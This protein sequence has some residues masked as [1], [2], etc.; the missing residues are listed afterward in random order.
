MASSDLPR[1]QPIYMRL[2]GTDEF[3][4][5]YNFFTWGLKGTTSLSRQG[6]KFEDAWIQH[7]KSLELGLTEPLAGNLTKP[8][9]DDETRTVVV[10][11]MDSQD[12]RILTSG[13]T[14]GRYAGKDAAGHDVWET[15]KP[16]EK[17]SKSGLTAGR[18]KGKDAAGKDVWET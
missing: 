9:Y 17:E 14:A 18:Y 8:H 15:E 2:L 10:D 5:F 16:V 3:D 4:A 13:L 11:K 12:D 6:A 7:C 1:E